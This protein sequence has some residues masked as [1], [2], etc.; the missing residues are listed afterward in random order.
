MSTDQFSQTVSGSNT[1]RFTSVPHYHSQTTFSPLFELVNIPSRLVLEKVYLNG[2]HALRRF[3]I[4]NISQS[5][6]LVKLRSNLGSQIAF[7]L[8]NENL[9]DIDSQKADL[10]LTSSELNSTSISEED[11]STLFNVSLD[12]SL[13]NIATNTVAAAAAGAF[14]DNM[15]GHE[16]NQLFNYVNHIEEVIIP[17]GCSQKIILVFLPDVH[18]KNRRSEEDQGL[19]SS[20]NDIIGV[21][22]AGISN[23]IDETRLNTNV[24][25]QSSEEDE[26]YDFFEVNG[27]LFFFSYIIDKQQDAE[28]MEISNI[29]LSNTDGTAT[30]GTNSL[31]LTNE[32]D[33]AVSPRDIESISS[34]SKADYQIT[35]KFRSKVCRSVLWTDVGETGI[36]FDDCV[37]GGTYFK[38]FTIWNRSEIELYWLLNTVDLSNF[39]RED[40]LKFTDYDTGELL[41]DKPI[42]S[43]SHRRIRVTFKPREIGEFNYDLQIENA[44]DPSNIL[45][46]RIHAVVRSVL[47]EESL[48]VSSGNILDFGDCCAG[49][50]SIQQLIL[51]NV[52]EVPLEIHFSAENAEVLF[53]L[54][55]DNLIERN[56]IDLKDNSDYAEDMTSFHHHFKDVVNVSGSTPTTSNTPINTSS[57]GSE[58]SSRPQSP[59]EID[60]LVSSV[61]R[62]SYIKESQ[63]EASR[64]AS[65][66]R[67]SNIVGSDMEGFLGG[68]DSGKGFMIKDTLEKGNLVL[69][70]SDEITQIEEVIFGP[71]REKT[72]QVSYRPEKDSS[73][74]DFKA[75]R[76]T[77]R[78]FRII[79]QY[80]PVNSSSTSVR[81]DGH[82]RKIIQCRARSCTSFIE[83]NP[84]EVN[85]G[86]TDVG[87]PKSAPVKITNL[88]EL[89][90]RVELQFVS[91][92]LNCTRDEIIIPP[93]LSTE[94]KLYMY[95]RKVNVDYRKQ[96]TVVNLQNRDNDQI[97]Q[98]RSTNID[99]NRVTFHSL[100]YRILTSTGGNFIDFGLTVIN[101]PSIR[102]FTIHNISKKNLVL[103]IT[104]LL[105]EIIMYQK[106]IKSV[107]TINSEV[108]HSITKNCADINMADSG[109]NEQNNSSKLERREKL[110]ESIGNKRSNIDI[111]KA[112][113]NA[114]GKIQ[115][116]LS[117]SPHALLDSA[118]SDSSL[119]SASYLDLASSSMMRSPRRRPLKVSMSKASVLGKS[120]TV[121]RVKGIRTLNNTQINLSDI[122]MNKLSHEKLQKRDF[123]NKNNGSINIS[124]GNSQTTNMNEE[125][126]LS[127]M[128]IESLIAILEKN[129]GTSPPLFPKPSIEAAYVHKRMTLLRELQNRIRDNQIVPVKM[130]EI[131]PNGERQIIV[132]FTPKRQ[133][134][135]TIQGLPKKYDAKI[136][137]RLIDFD[138]EIQQP[139]FDV[140][141]RGDQSQIPVRELMVN[142]TI[143]S[144]IMDL[145]QKNINFGIMDKNERRSKKI[146]IQNRSEV[147]LLYYIRKSG[148][149][150]SDYIV[151]NTGNMGVVRGYGKKEIEFTFNPSLPGQ[152]HEKLEIMNI[153]DRDNDQ[154][155]SVKAIIKKQ[156]NFFIQPLNMNFGACLINENASQVQH[157]TIINTN[158][159][160]RTLEVRI[161]PQELKFEWCCGE[162]SFVLK[163]DNDGSSINSGLLSEEAEE[164]IENLE[165][166]V[167]IAKRKGREE[168]VKK[169]EK[170]LEK[171]RRGETR[172]DDDNY[173]E[174]EE[175]ASIGNNNEFIKD[176]KSD[177]LSDGQQTPLE[178]SERLNEHAH[179]SSKPALRIDKNF[180]LSI[181]RSNMSNLISGKEVPKYKK[182]P[183]SI[184]FTMEPRTSKTI[185]IY[186]KAIA[187]NT[188][189]ISQRPSQET[190]TSR[191]FVHEHKNTDAMKTVVFK[192]TV[193]YNHSSASSDEIFNN[194]ENKSESS[195]TSSTS[196]LSGIVSEIGENI[197][198]ERPSPFTLRKFPG[199]P[200]L[201]GF[202]VTSSAFIDKSPIKEF[203]SHIEHGET[204]P[205]T[206][207][208]VLEP[209][210]LDIGRLEVNQ[211][212]NYY[213][214]LSNR[215]NHPLDY[216]III[217]E[218]ERAF[219]QINQK[220]GTLSSQETRRVDFSVTATVV[221]KQ[222]HKLQVRNSATKVE[223][224]F[225]LHGYVHYS[226]Y[227]RFPSLR[228]DGQSELNLGYCY[229]DPGRKFSQ[230]TPL[231]VENISDD[232]VYITA[233]SNLSLQVSVFLDENGIRGQVSKTLLKKKSVTTV[234]VALHPNLLSVVPTSRRNVNAGTTTGSSVNG[235]NIV[236]RNIISNGECR[237]LIG[238]IKFSV[239]V[240]E[241][242]RSSFTQ[243]SD[244]TELIEAITQTVK[245]ISL[246]GRSILSVSEKLISLGSTTSI[247]ETFYGSFTIRNMSSRLPLDYVVECPSGNILLDRTYGSL[248]GWECKY[249]QRDSQEVTSLKD[250]NISPCESELEDKSIA[251]IN[252]RVTTSKYGLLR[253]KIIVTNKNNTG[254]VVEVEIRLFVDNNT[255]GFLTREESSIT[256]HIVLEKTS[257]IIENTKDSGK[258]PLLSWENISTTIIESESKLTDSDSESSESKLD[259][260]AVIQKGYQATVVPLYE[261]CIEICNKSSTDIMRIRPVSDLDIKVRWGPFGDTRIIENY[262]EELNVIDPFHRCGLIV[263]L[264]PGYKAHLYVSCPQ[265]N[266]LTNEELKLIEDGKKVKI[267]G[268]LLLNDITQ[269]LTLKLIDLNANFCV[270]KGELST[271][272]INLG[273]IRHSNSLA[274]FQFTLR[275]LSEIPLHYELQS[276]DCIEILG[277]NDDGSKAQYKGVIALKRTVEPLVDQIITAVLKPRRIENF[278]AGERIFYVNVLNMYNPHNI[279]TLHVQATL[280]LF[281]LKFDRL[282]QGE[283]VLPTLYHPI[284]RSD[285]PCDA[286]FTIHNISEKDIRFEIGMELSPY[287]SNFIKIDILSRFSN[288]PLVG[289]V[290]ISAHGS[291]EVRVRAY[292]IETSRIPQESLYLVNPDGVTFGKLW[293]DTKQNNEDDTVA[294]IIPIRGFITESPTFSVSTKKIR[295][296]TEFYS[297]DNEITNDD[298][299][300]SSPIRKSKV[301]ASNKGEKIEA[302]GD[303]EDI[304]PQTES[305]IITNLSKK[306]P[307]S[308]KVIIE[309]PMELSA[310]EI[311]NVFPLD[312]NGY[313]TIEPGQTFN[314]KIELVDSTIAVSE[315]IKIRIIDL[316]SLS[317]HDKIVLVGIESVTCEPRK[318]PR[319]EE[320]S[321]SVPEEA[322]E[323]RFH[324][325]K[326]TQTGHLTVS[327][328][329]RYSYKGTSSDFPFITLR[330]CKRIGEATDIGGRYELDLGQQDLGPTPIVKKLTLENTTLKRVSYEI[331]T[332]SASDKNWL[333]IG[334]TEGTLEA[335]AD[336]H[337]RQYTHVHTITLSFSTSIRNVYSTY[338][339]IK[340][341]DNPSDTKTI[342]VMME[343]V[344][345]QNL[346][347]GA[348]VSLANNH[349]FDIYVNG[350]D[351]SQTWIEMF[352]LFYGSE[353][354]ARSM[355]IYNRENVPLEFT[356]Q[357]NLD[358]D[359]PTEILFSTSRMSVKLFKT[360]TVEPESH[361][362]VYMR[363]RPLPSREIQELLDSGN[364]R[365]PDLV[366]KKTIE[367]YVNCRLV[368]DYQQTVLLKAECRMPSLQVSYNETE[369]FMGKIWRRYSNNKDDDEWNFQF[370]PEFREIKINNLLDK[371]LEYEIVNDTMYFNLELSDDVKE[372]APK[373][374]HNILVRPNL[375]S[376]IKNAESVRREK[377]IQEI[378]TVYNRNRPSENYWIS[379]R[380]SFGHISN[381]QFSSGYKSSYTYSILENYTVRF[382]SN[383]NN[384]T[385]VFDSAETNEDKKKITDLEIQYLYIVDQL[386]YYA[387]IK[388]GENWF[389]LA[390]LLFG[391]VLENKIFQKYR[392]SY[393]KSPDPTKNEVRVW[394]PIL[395]KWVL[396]L[397]YFISFFPYRNPML[398]TLKELHKNLI[399]SNSKN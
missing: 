252:F 102:T 161:D 108:L 111:A 170:K 68:S 307:L 286:W 288:S 91:K 367:I 153:Q 270:P 377:Y 169:I 84:K 256:K 239:Q 71:G 24:F 190:I 287:I 70:T 362:R 75:G 255:L 322:V 154:V 306:I 11:N 354:S 165:R 157:F 298:N 126:T 61:E 182:T 6:I 25:T 1:T 149:I 388:S 392:P 278:S 294:E 164:E 95:P 214:K 220:Y 284:P 230:V 138:R 384:N 130:V 69:E 156:S 201:K 285:F 368:K 327:Q 339:I 397:N 90:A 209:T 104:S 320:L 249:C 106:L 219:F 398:E 268:V 359:D 158:K 137:I 181:K 290:S 134:R 301:Y 363:S 289:S 7:Q 263:E 297:S 147:P 188:E 371:P 116:S 313:G 215:S 341:L 117:H 114:S 246:I 275:N 38:D 143:C 177:I 13:I 127:S 309:G 328:D 146:L 40:W 351:T 37:N 357:T 345:R 74:N 8:K 253:D 279:M 175:D 234:W 10:L 31:A 113:L 142:T 194:S 300:K 272:M 77:R 393:L 374:V 304:L 123:E 148:S 151:F 318:K 296:K 342:R 44:N 118:L 265:P 369:A 79:L 124:S 47:R 308:F 34:S 191:I 192:A 135:P 216:E 364:Q 212:H 88:S 110:L 343:V 299:S 16:F 136:F 60:G 67:F 22:S 197:V 316:N 80:V 274:E 349:V 99:K 29:G 213:F 228:D 225:V 160:S 329:R 231:I 358:Y 145:G 93:K 159:L 131:P 66:H 264:K 206:E 92:V 94:V 41:D 242:T 210:T 330:G 45:Q 229:V 355:V 319:I 53:H 224:T 232:D 183:T 195:L 17:Q 244:E 173:N 273:K 168:K 387:T 174:L 389:Q 325:F 33:Q 30:Y 121:K 89:T 167:K 292:P 365:D 323:P 348:N 254:Q 383:F 303:S 180:D 336:E 326:S 338:L 208:L 241:N 55:T 235:T 87:T 28:N 189:N 283:L 14:S 48:V 200:S 109:E 269:G 63:S 280:T 73:A 82:E 370:N 356:F 32:T 396:P 141:L 98:V 4:R 9:P 119:S 344:A 291:I 198:K 83:V 57:I 259:L 2:L 205:E 227:L 97:I 310:K 186:F 62:L 27:L 78:T 196:E 23:G 395:A 166:K 125:E 18:H 76:L 237:E 353:Y 211:S 267:Q 122:N 333:N 293:V 140:L 51:K 199:S 179:T 120:P 3:E 394:P 385:H 207:H 378:V 202:D 315:D 302:S 193:C 176:E 312:D 5:T 52:S 43:Y 223:Y 332:V 248:D 187:I 233:Q 129:N 305:V 236:D 150:S 247:G 132:V 20:T 50:W 324:L 243:K 277:I 335:L 350:V 36:N 101:S 314:L 139:Q 361:V 107:D 54:K 340:N 172:K 380:I 85:F 366:E 217:S 222:S 250:I 35:V 334:R 49:V 251:L 56:K 65:G 262:N 226:Q 238:G 204:L 381:F 379:L 311:I 282:I 171:L 58:V 317:S 271:T 184:I 46:S 331:K 221:G 162:L 281:E 42:P 266:S 386:V 100:F 399:I 372:V 81:S 203:S 382:L 346:K 376:L 105:P 96:I 103:E 115:T 258:L 360:L 144:S 295:F 152:F 133:L 86:D 21:S 321:S 26:T 59:H 261:R 218:D 375:K 352:N 245:F 178:D 72:V 12:S 276:P 240:K 64:L 39:E 163:E 15:N 19:P 185:Y 112:N 391:T 257:M 155:I 337:Y 260:K 128:P 390:S 373:S 347:R